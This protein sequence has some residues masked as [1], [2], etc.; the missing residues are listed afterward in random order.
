MNQRNAA[1]LMAGLLFIYLVLVGQRAVMFMLSGDTV[2]QMIGG[3]LLIFPCIAAWAI[4]RELLFGF[5]SARLFRDLDRS[6]SLPGWAGNAS[7]ER[8]R[9]KP[10]MENHRTSCLAEL[11]EQPDSWR[12]WF[13]LGLAHDGCGERRLAREAIR[14]AI[15][16]SRRQGPRQPRSEL[17]DTSS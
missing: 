12:A 5:R 14:R 7:V 11:A 10:E 6:D 1:V 9:Q 8:S 4:C 2:G 16:L 3:A 13:C 17:F 15:A